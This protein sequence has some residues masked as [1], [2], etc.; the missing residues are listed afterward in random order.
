[1]TNGQKIKYHLVLNINRAFGWLP[2]GVRYGPV[3]YI[4]YFLLYRVFRYRVSVVRRN[5]AASFPEKSK[6]ELRSI[7]KGFYKHLAEVFIDTIDVVSITPSEAKKRVVFENADEHEKEV[8]GKDWIAAMAHYGC[9]EY[10]TVYQFHTL[11]QVVGVYR[12]VKDKALD[13]FYRYSRSRFGMEPVSM[14]I[15]MRYILQKKQTSPRKLA[16][17]MIADQSART[18]NDHVMW[19]DFLN[20]KTIFN[21]GID[22]I[23]RKLSMP[24]Y[25]TEVKKIGK[26]RY[27]S[28]FVRIYDGVEDVPEGEITARYAAILE[29][30]IHSAPQF[31]M[32]SHKRWKRQFRK[33]SRYYSDGKIT[34]VGQ[35]GN[36]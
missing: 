5:L 25:Y 31:W 35:D 21:S 14:K 18:S 6:G 30:N 3:L 34:V 10:F 13:E 16:I 29:K 36:N 27:T 28:R 9:W 17:G 12:P 8:A 33:G 19:F 7:E 4:F 24:V 20:Q 15:L 26:A 32:W 2:T 23:A 22:R 11:S 1:M